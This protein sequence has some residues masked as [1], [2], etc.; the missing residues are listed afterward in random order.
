MFCL[1]PK[2]VKKT[3]INRDSNNQLDFNGVSI[4]GPE[5]G[6]FSRMSLKSSTSKGLQ[7]GVVARARL[8]YNRV[9]KL[10]TGEAARRLQKDSFS[11]LRTAD[12]PDYKNRYFS[13]FL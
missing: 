11:K 3:I 7:R 2:R 9:S 12:S 4:A 8:N 10:G 13:I 6:N 1:N 5:K